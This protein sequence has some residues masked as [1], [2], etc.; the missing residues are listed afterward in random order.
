M[1]EQVANIADSVIQ[2]IDRDWPDEALENL[3]RE[4]IVFQVEQVINSYSEDE[5]RNITDDMIAE[6]VEEICSYFSNYIDIDKKNPYEDEK[7]D[8]KR[9]KHSVEKYY[10]SLEYDF[11]RRFIN[12]KIDLLNKIH[13]LYEK[14]Y[15]PDHNN[16]AYDFGD[17]DDPCYSS[18]YSP[19]S[20][21]IKGLHKQFDNKFNVMAELLI[22]NDYRFKNL[23]E[24][25][26][27]EAY[28]PSR[29]FYNISKYGADYY[30]TT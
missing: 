11:D 8:T 28:K 9:Y 14:Y 18:L 15:D 25:L 10:L 20:D 24:E 22:K 23:A 27:K 6:A 30:E 1:T 19:P 26:A 3:D 13:I 29:V 17:S 4:D 12:Y 2:T 16:D 21:I 5:I 7:R